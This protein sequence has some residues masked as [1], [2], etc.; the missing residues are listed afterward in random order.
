MHELFYRNMEP[1]YAGRYRDIPV[2]ITGSRYP[3]A[4]PEKIPGEMERLFQV[5]FPDQGQDH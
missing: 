4:A 2:I 1:G 3:L 5:P